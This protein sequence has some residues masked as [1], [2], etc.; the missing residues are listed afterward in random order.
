MSAAEP[1]AAVEDVPATTDGDL[2]T[3]VVGAP[4]NR[5][6]APAH[7]LLFSQDDG[8]SAASTVLTGTTADLSATG[9][10]TQEQTRA[11]ERPEYPTSAGRFL[12]VL[13][14]SVLAFQLTQ[15]GPQSL[16]QLVS[17][18]AMAETASAGWNQLTPIGVPANGMTVVLN[19]GIDAATGDPGLPVVNAAIGDSAD[20]GTQVVA[21]AGISGTPG[22]AGQWTIL[23]GSAN[24]LGLVGFSLVNRADGLCLDVGDQ[25]DGSAAVVTAVCDNGLGQKWDYAYGPGGNVKLL[26]NEQI[27]TGI[28]V[29]D[30]IP[31]WEPGTTAPLIVGPGISMPVGISQVVEPGSI[32]PSWSALN[33]TGESTAPFDLATGD[34]DS[35]VDASGNFHDEAAV[36]YVGADGSAQI[37]VID[38]NANDD[39][40][41]VTS[42]A[43]GVIGAGSSGKRGSLTIDSADLDG[44]G[45]NEL[46]VSFQDGSGALHLALLEYAADP[47]TGARTL[48]VLAADTAVPNGAG[49]GPLNGYSDST[50]W[51]FDGDGIAEFV[52]G[53][54]GSSSAS[55]A[56]VTFDSTLSITG[57]A[58]GYL[59][60]WSSGRGRM[61]L[62]TGAFQTAADDP[63]GHR[64]LAA[65]WWTG[66]QTGLP[67]ERGLIFT[68][69]V[70]VISDPATAIG[71]GI[72]ASDMTPGD[73]PVSLIPSW[74]LEMPD[75]PEWPYWDVTPED[76]FAL[77]AGAFGAPA[78]GTAWSVAA[79]STQG[80]FTVITPSTGIVQQNDNR[81]PYLPTPSL[82]A[83]DRAGDSMVVG[84]PLVLTVQNLVDLQLVGG[85]PPAHADWLNGEFVNISRNEDFSLQ[86]GSSSTDTYENSSSHESNS[87]YQITENADVKATAS[88]GIPGIE[89]GE[90]SLEVKQ[91]FDY[92]WNTVSTSLSSNSSSTTQTVTQTAVDDDI[93]NAEVQDFRI[94]RYPVLS[95]SSYDNPEAGADCG[96]GCYGYWDVVIPSASGDVHPIRSSGRS[97]AYFQPPWQNGNALSYPAIQDGAVPIDDLGSYTD[98]SGATQQATLFNQNN[99]LAGTK[100][101]AELDVDTSTS[102]STS[103]TSTKSWDVGVDV[104]AGVSVQAGFGPFGKGQ[105]DAS[106]EGGFNASKAS[107]NT[108]TGSTT[109]TH[110]GTF[111]LNMPEVAE[112]RGYDVAAAYY[113]STGGYPKVTYAVDVTAVKESQEWWTDNYGQKSDLALNLPDNSL[114][115]Y[116]SHNYLGTVVWNDEQSRQLI[117][118]FTATRPV[119]PSS[120]TTSGA[121]YATAPNAG[122]PVFFNVDVHNYSLDSLDAPFTVDFYAVPV[123]GQNLNVTGPAQPI[124]TQTVGGIAAQSDVTVTSPEWDAV[125][126]SNGSGSQNWRIFVVLDAA[127]AIPEVHEWKPTDAGDAPCPTS[128]VQD[129]SQLID[130]MTGTADQLACGQNNQ[131]YGE[132]VVM[133]GDV[134]A[135]AVSTA[136][137]A[138]VQLA[139][140]G[141]TTG[142][143]DDLTIGVESDIPSVIAGESVTGLVHAT[144]DSDS[145]DQQLVLVYDGDPS[146]GNVIAA[147]YLRGVSAASGGHATYTWTPTTPGVHELHQVVLG[148]AAAGDKDEQIVRVNVV[149]PADGGGDPTPPTDPGSSPQPSS[150]ASGSNGGRLA[151]TGFDAV[152]LVAI[153]L[154]AMGLGGIAVLRRRRRVG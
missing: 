130:P 55:L 30:D 151:S 6:L 63:L 107:T 115:T 144:A 93:V 38:Y 17:S 1:L 122:D 134:Q 14:D 138:N 110:S 92:T 78:P 46:V 97:L 125:G 106:L 123:D 124:G 68:P 62:A 75:V 126:P 67:G 132:I 72:V 86:L 49:S 32:A 22:F 112:D 147:T 103:E 42:A 136:D 15:A 146:E 74:E 48:T 28:A 65:G 145:R 150:D 113:Y 45:G 81:G 119:D 142:N 87:T 25:S 109:N 41:L 52:L 94:L 127:G 51:D 111:E 90:A 100:S 85:Q 7:Q 13:H 101:M 12:D 61:H 70:A 23:G 60:E 117:R 9:S 3:D 37:D 139:G 39:H 131:G 98:S 44:D 33:P 141:L 153:A 89:E 11:L 140:A 29:S 82:T 34:L 128:S 53:F 66:I 91:S 79:A 64:Q 137:R 104:T 27:T 80:L 154:A 152:I 18:N 95:T 102:T 71:T 36:A 54:V 116:D 20:L 143:P 69:L 121:I 58:A 56:R 40:L 4:V 114:L 26:I 83:Y 8:S 47:D 76:G 96:T 19:A 73:S 43:L 57:A 77:T 120:P 133:S 50:A 149:D 2:P 148:T 84:P 5:N 108:T 129:G 31:G 21:Q 35:A 16:L 105:V 10:A 135:D 59:D 24:E 88:E 118:G 99:T